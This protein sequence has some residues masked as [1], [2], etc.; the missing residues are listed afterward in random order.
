VLG[1]AHVDVVVE[2]VVEENDVFWR[3]FVKEDVGFLVADVRCG[4]CCLSRRA[5]N[6]VSSNRTCSAMTVLCRRG[7]HTR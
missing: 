5:G 3:D 7:N 2:N 1:E 6:Q 4:N